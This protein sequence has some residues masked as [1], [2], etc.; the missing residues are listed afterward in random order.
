M[1]RTLRHGGDE[2]FGAGD[3]FVAGRMML[4]E[5][6]ESPDPADAARVLRTI[7]RKARAELVA[8]SGMSETALLAE[9][10][11]LLID[12]LMVCGLRRSSAQATLR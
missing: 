2:Q 7:A 9:T 6:G 12:L 3:Q 4:A 10:R 5:P 11:S 1:P 8:E